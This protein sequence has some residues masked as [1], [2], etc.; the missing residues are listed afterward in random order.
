M[1]EA[2]FCVLLA[3]VLLETSINSSCSKTKSESACCPKTNIF[4]A[5]MFKTIGAGKI[6]EVREERSAMENIIGGR[7]FSVKKS[8]ISSIEEFGHFEQYFKKVSIIDFSKE[9]LLGKLISVDVNQDGMLL[10]VDALAANV[11]L[12]D[13]SGNLV[14]KLSPENCLSGM[15]WRPIMAKF[16][17]KDKI[18]VL[19]S[20]PQVGVIFSR[21]GGCASISIEKNAFTFNVNID[22]EDNIYSFY[23]REKKSYITK[24]DVHG[25]R[26]LT[27]GDFRRPFEK[28]SAHH[29]GGGLVCGNGA[30]YQA[31][32]TGPEVYVFNSNGDLID[33]LK[34]SPSFFKPIESDLVAENTTQSIVFE[35]K[36]L[37]K[38]KTFVHS[39]FLLEEDKLL[40]QYMH[41]RSKTIIDIFDLNGK[42]LVDRGILTDN[43]I[44]ALAKSRKAYVITQ[45]GWDQNKELPNPRLEV[46]EFTGNPKVSGVRIIPHCGVSIIPHF[47][48]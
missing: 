37:M 39:L 34:R 8:N 32:L 12:F 38:G 18:F 6:R 3:A 25:K 30:I 35:T 14:K 44:I 47:F 48:Q 16:M 4:V 13:T 36:K 42:P 11:Y 19:T 9:V 7:N 21:E 29:A 23:A 31:L 40:M 26:L 41:D 24:T 20:S 33:T 27:F 2:S 1:R 43:Y 28:L 17:A 22:A 46:Y 45:P 5:N 10:V 15:P